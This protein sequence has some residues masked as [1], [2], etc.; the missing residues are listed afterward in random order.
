MFGTQL[1]PFKP[2][3]F[4]ST[5]QML[6]HAALFCFCNVAALPGRPPRRP[7]GRFREW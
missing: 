3:Y 5:G 6:V 4:F 1:T 2:H 7:P